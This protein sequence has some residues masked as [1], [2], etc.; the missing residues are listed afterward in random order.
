MSVFSSA[1]FDFDAKK[2]ALFEQLPATGAAQLA[3]G[4]DHWSQ[5][6]GNQ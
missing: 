5:A 1:E 3:G 6:G 4:L 2:R